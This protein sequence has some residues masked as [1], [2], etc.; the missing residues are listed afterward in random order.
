MHVGPMAGARCGSLIDL[1]VFTW[2]TGLK[3]IRRAW[4]VASQ[5]R[6]PIMLA[7]VPICAVLVMLH[8]FD[9]P[10]CAEAGRYEGTIMDGLRIGRGAMAY[11]TGDKYVGDFNHDASRPVGSLINGDEYMD[12]GP[13]KFGVFEFVDGAT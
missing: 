11:A 13:S 1:A 5:V 8:R 10:E 6:R 3:V 2:V 7:V 4:V 12:G 9:P